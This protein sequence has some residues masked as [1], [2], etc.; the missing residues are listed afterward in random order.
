MESYNDL[1]RDWDALRLRSN[2]WTGERQHEASPL[3]PTNCLTKCRL[4][5]RERDK[6]QVLKLLLTDESNCQGVNSAVPIVGPAGVAK[7]SL[8]QH[9]YND[10]ALR[11][12]FY[13]KTWIWAC[14]EF[15]VLKLT[16]KLAEEAM[17]SPWGFIEMNQLHHIIANR[18]EGK[19]FLLVLDDVVTDL[20]QYQTFT[21]QVKLNS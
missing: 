8:V 10:K 13:I 7:T 19:Q 16:R 6:R 18:L 21:A 1:A 17:E 4:R 3:T 15:D 14:Q 12:K 11:S 2:D 9:I 20:L 5:G